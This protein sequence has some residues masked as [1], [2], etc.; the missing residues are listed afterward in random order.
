MNLVLMCDVFGFDGSMSLGLGRLGGGV[1]VAV[2][3]ASISRAV[4]LHPKCPTERGGGI[5]DFHNSLEFGAG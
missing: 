5:R 2:Q 3:F 4:L 1:P